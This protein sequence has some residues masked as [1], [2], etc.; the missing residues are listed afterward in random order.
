M[1]AASSTN[2]PLRKP[3]A[4]IVRAGSSL[5]KTPALKADAEALLFSVKSF[6]AAML[7]YGIS[8]HI[9]LAKPYWAIVTV[10]IVS[11]NSAGASLSRGVY[12]FTGTVVGTVAT[13][14]IVPNF[15][16]DPMTCSVMLA[17]WI[18]LCLYFSLLDR[19]PRAYAFVLAGYTV[20]LIGFPS[21][22]DPGAVFT[23]ASMRVQEISIG[24]LCSIL[25]H[26][27]VLPKRM[28]GQFTGKLSA[29]LRNARRLAGDAFRGASEQKTHRD[30]TQL[31]LDLLSLQGL[32]THLPY[33]P[34]DAAPRRKTL[35]RVHDRLAQLLPL[36]MEIEDRLHVLGSG[37]HT[38]PDELIAL[39]AD[40]EDWI[41][42]VAGRDGTASD[43]IARARSL[44]ARIGAD[45]ATPGDRLAANLAGHLA[46]TICLIQDCNRLE[47][48]IGRAG[49]SRDDTPDRGPARA[50]GYVYHRDH[51]MAA[52]AALG[53]ILGIVIG[54]TFWIRSAWPD[55]GMAVSIFG[56]CCTLFGN[57]DSP[58]PNVIKYMIGLVYGVA[59]SLVYSFVI[60][61]R[62]TD[63]DV[64]VAVLA[65]AFLFAGSLQARPSA[66]L[67][68][69]G[70]TLTI[71][72]VG[73][74]GATYGGSFAGVLNS[75]VA[76]FAA[77]GF[78][79]ASMSL[80][81][82][83]PADA[84]ITRLSRLTRRDVRRLTRGGARSKVH[85]TNLMVD[86][87]ALLLPRLAQSKNAPASA[88][89]DL[90]RHLRVGHA[91]DRLREAIRRGD[92]DIGHAARELLSAVAAHYGS[93]RRKG[94]VETAD[95]DRRIE[96][97]SALV[98]ASGI[99]DRSRWLDLLVDLRFA[100]L[101]QHATDRRRES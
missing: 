53:A 54:C 91:A 81:Q 74:L 43:L 84:A 40:A 82:T 46:E 12:R 88:L 94:P 67:M 18:G 35:K 14:A 66:T 5:L 49:R 44:Q 72:I 60:L 31:A 39:L 9:G 85:W 65:P 78:G 61:P 2:R 29:T 71:P 57:V 83:T 63:F 7:A 3:L 86:R 27:F 101:P 26:R 11:Q 96:R 30:R 23:T 48:N 4:T 24:I 64:L 36:T 10:Y 6:A 59:I 89:D 21:V 68:A 52:R 15:V 32:A 13:V 37:G 58:A 33:D 34:A 90:L 79:I 56:V 28:T 45:G 55:G 75:V 16:N 22:L 1:N 19:T 98:T 38:T 100:L 41:D 76:V 20:S 80:F 69:L 87:T 99:E 51:W 17:C 73:G 42:A 62:V 25:M 70:I 77:I 47:R 8:L 97:L 93:G 50:R 95:L 92:G